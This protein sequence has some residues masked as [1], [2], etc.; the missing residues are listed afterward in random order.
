IIVGE[1]LFTRNSFEV[2][3][4]FEGG[5]YIWFKTDSVLYVT[6]VSRQGKSTW[7]KEFGPEK[8]GDFVRRISRADWRPMTVGKDGSVFVLTDGFQCVTKIAISGEVLWETRISNRASIAAGIDNFTALADADGG[9]IV[10]WEEVGEFVGIRAQR[11][12][13]YGNLGG[14][15][16]VGESPR[17]PLPENFILEPPYP[18]PFNDTVKIA[19]SIP[20]TSTIS[21]KVYDILAREVITLKQDRLFGGSHAVIWDGADQLGRK[22]SSGIYLLVLRSGQV[23]VNQ[24]LL[25]LK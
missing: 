9:G 24:K 5:A 4:D 17:P 6:H 8:L 21:L 11:V 10:A 1:N 15:T 12:D 18:N 16:P 3:S 20:E 2:H 14:T 23:S 22:L 25:L 7:K 13:R 19:F